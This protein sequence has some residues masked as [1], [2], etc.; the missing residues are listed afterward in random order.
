MENKLAVWLARKMKIEG[1]SIRE[2]ARRAGLS[3]TTVA[4][5]LS[6][7][8]EPTWEF[9]AKIASVVREPPERTFR[10][11]G[12]LSLAPEEE[13]TIQEL[14]DVVRNLPI[15]RQKEMLWY[16]LAL[17]GRNEEEE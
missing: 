2:V 6:G 9:C 1:W 12:L 7:Q 3:H 15:E 17:Y 11:A 13:I 4:E 14:V 8:R 16:A 5:V 10:R